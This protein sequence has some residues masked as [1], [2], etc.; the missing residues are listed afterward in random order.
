MIGSDT[1][2]ADPSSVEY[3]AGLVTGEL[4]SGGVAGMARGMGSTLRALATGAG[5]SCARGACGRAGSGMIGR[6][7]D[8]ASD[9]K[10]F[11]A[12]TLV[13]TPEGPRAIETLAVGDW[14]WAAQ[15]DGAAVVVVARQVVAVHERVAG[16]RLRL[17][18]QS[19]D[20]ERGELEVTGEHPIFDAGLGRYVWA[21]DL[22]AGAVLVL[23]DGRRAA[24]ESVA[25]VSGAAVVYNLEVEV[26]H[27]YFA[28][29]PSGNGA[30]LVHN[31]K[32][33]G[34]KRGPKTDAPHNAKIRSEADS[35]EAEG[36]R[37]L[38][39]GGRGREKL[40]K[41]TGGIKSGRR[42]DIT[43]STPSGQV[44]GRNVGRTNADG[45]P[46]RREAEALQD[47]NG[48]GNLPTDYVAYDR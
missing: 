15:L 20:G 34:A 27:N 13:D 47:L 23:G 19:D 37:I 10:C 28:G 8:L 40:V 22:R 31:G 45:T 33:P 46:V 32:Y 11:V 17:G 29:G 1:L 7:V 43:Y 38:H 24:V 35:L 14:V 9:A 18:Y 3:S 16:E 42:P 41:T 2:S 6:L 5:R 21:E 48:P 36:N 30:I 12:G 39:G 4:V 26:S 44:R 25:R